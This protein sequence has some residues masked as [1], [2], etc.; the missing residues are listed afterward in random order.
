MKISDLRFPF[1]V[2]RITSGQDANG[3]PID[4]DSGFSS[5][6]AFKKIST[7][8]ALLSGVDTSTVRGVITFYCVPEREIL[9]NDIITLRGQDWTPEGDC[10]QVEEG[11]VLYFRQMLRHG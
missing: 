8:Q 6:C 5:K 10:E 4:A 3:D 7:K 1:T 9:V 2:K 11:R